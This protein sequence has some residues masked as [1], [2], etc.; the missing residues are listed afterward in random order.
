VSILAIEVTRTAEATFLNVDVGGAS[1]E[2]K[3]D[4]VDEYRLGD[5]MRIIDQVL[6]QANPGPCER[7]I[8]GPA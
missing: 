4:A 5:A 3:L 8:A 1:I 7:W 2:R 6:G